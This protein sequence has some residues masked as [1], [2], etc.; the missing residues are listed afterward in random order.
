[1]VRADDEGD[2][3]K[4]MAPYS[5]DSFD[6][7]QPLKVRGRVTC[8][9]VL[10]FPTPECYWTPCSYHLLHIALI[11]CRDSNGRGVVVTRVA[12]VRL[13][14]RSSGN[15]ET[16]SSLRQCTASVACD[17]HSKFFFPVRSKSGAAKVAICGIKLLYYI[18]IPKNERSCFMDEKG[19]TNDERASKR[20][21]EGAM[22][23][24]ERTW[25]KKGTDG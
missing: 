11:H 16:I 15:G 6:H 7:C 9:R 23:V 19:G 12:S 1:M 5:R 21:S 4:E 24:A 18:T 8:L 17:V 13:K 3:F 10:Q 14:R 25:P 22:P 2:V 20:R